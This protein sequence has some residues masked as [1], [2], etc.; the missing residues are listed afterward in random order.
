MTLQD[1]IR[2]AFDGPLAL[3]DEDLRR[4]VA[5]RRSRRRAAVGSA[6][7]L[8]L[9]AGLVGAWAVLRHDEPSSVVAGPADVSATV[10][11]TEDALAGGRWVQV[12]PAATAPAWVEFDDAGRAIVGNACHTTDGVLTTLDDRLRLEVA[13]VEPTQFCDAPSLTGYPQLFADG[14]LVVGDTELRRIETLGRPASRD[15]LLGAWQTPD[16]EIDVT[17]DER[18]RVGPCSFAFVFE[19]GRMRSFNPACDFIVGPSYVVSETVL[20]GWPRIDGDDLWFTTPDGTAHLVRVDTA[21]P[22]VDLTAGPWAPEDVTGLVDLPRLVFGPD[23]SFEALGPCSTYRGTWES[24]G[25]GPVVEITDS[26]VA[27]CQDVQGGDRFVVGARGELDL[28]GEVLNVAGHR[29]RQLGPDLAVSSEDALYGPWETEDGRSVVFAEDT[30]TIDGTCATV[31]WELGTGVLRYHGVSTCRIAVD[32]VSNERLGLASSVMV[33][34]DGDQLFLLR[35]DGQIAVYHPEASVEG[36]E[37]LL[38]RA[39]SHE[40]LLDPRWEN[41]GDGDLDLVGFLWHGELVHVDAAPIGQLPDGEGHLATCGA[42]E[43]RI[44][45]PEAAA[46]ALFG[47]LDCASD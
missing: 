1:T 30:L 22:A 47:A 6:A 45:G 16:G 10:P 41:A 17:F 21:P 33:R 26:L 38:Y 9:V 5:R 2:S 44:D 32:P 39:I 28:D 29:F 27:Y 43:I 14:R 19:G 4:R 31:G 18:I 40:L 13:T 37:S 24:S 35:D 15:D 12:A 23:G 34:L 11:I 36:A 46:D 20:R 42:F 25:S 7:G 8:L 3:D